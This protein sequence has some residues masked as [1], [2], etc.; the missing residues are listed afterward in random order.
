MNSTN[1]IPLHCEFFS[2]FDTYKNDL[3]EMLSIK[4][5]ILEMKI[6]SKIV[7]T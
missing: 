4:P 5:L 6:K 7:H 3:E 2:C 1:F